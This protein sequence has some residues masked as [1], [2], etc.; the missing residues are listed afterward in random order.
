MINDRCSQTLLANPLS[1]LKSERL[2][3]KE[4]NPVSGVSH[5]SEG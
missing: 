4:Y 1:S 2:A 5:G 3:Q